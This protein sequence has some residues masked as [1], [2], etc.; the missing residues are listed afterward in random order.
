MRVLEEQLK[1]G[2]ISIEEL[3]A[4]RDPALLRKI[5]RFVLRYL[6]RILHLDEVNQVIQQHKGEGAV[7]FSEHIL[8]DFETTYRVYGEASLRPGRRY[9][10]ASNHPLGGFDGVVLMLS[11]IHI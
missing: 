5:P 7:E 2:T 11:L 8:Q 10:L 9:I 1:E 3:I 6:K 4:M